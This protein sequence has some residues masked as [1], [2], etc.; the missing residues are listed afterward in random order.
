MLN[1]HNETITNPDCSRLSAV[2]S[3]PSKEDTMLSL[4]IQRLGDVSVIQCSGRVTAGDGDILRIAVRTQS[5]TH[6]IVLD[7][8]EVSA[9]DA[10]GLGMLVG[11]RTWAKSTGTELKLMNLTPRVEEV[12]A[13]THLRPEFEV[14]SVREMMDLLCRATRSPRLDPAPAMAGV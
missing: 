9:I 14:C 13:L 2:E 11:L 7:L 12:L 1:L 10:A 8:A 3:H 5:R 4:T 6:T